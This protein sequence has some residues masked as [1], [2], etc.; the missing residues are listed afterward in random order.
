MTFT[1]S[2]PPGGGHRRAV[3]G[4]RACSQRRATGIRLSGG[5]AFEL[6]HWWRRR[7]W[8]MSFARIVTSAVPS[9]SGSSPPL[10]LSARC[11]ACSTLRCS[12]GPASARA[13]RGAR[14]GG[15]RIDLD[16]V[17]EAIAGFVTKVVRDSQQLEE[18]ESACSI[19]VVSGWRRTGPVWCAL[20]SGRARTR[21]CRSRRRRARR[22][23]QR[24]LPRSRQWRSAQC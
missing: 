21:A 20:R 15:W 1:P 4:V 23:R 22:G 7:P 18:A 12:C 6:R 9:S 8:P 24:V 2:L 17:E 13:A 3:A 5:G 10:R 19:G 16:A 14:T 11:A